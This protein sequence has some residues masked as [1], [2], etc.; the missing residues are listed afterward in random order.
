MP[1]MFFVYPDGTKK[2]VE[3]PVGL[4]VLGVYVYKRSAD[5]ALAAGKPILMWKV[6]NTEQGQKAAASHTANLGVPVTAASLVEAMGR[7]ETLDAVAAA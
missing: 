7:I 2:E 4:S 3:A 6:G 1:K 5:K